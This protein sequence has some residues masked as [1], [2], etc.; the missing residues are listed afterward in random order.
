L[1]HNKGELESARSTQLFNAH[2]IPSTVD[3]LGDDENHS[4]DENIQ[5]E[6]LHRERAFF[7]DYCT[8]DPSILLAQL[9]QESRKG[10]KG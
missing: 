5:Q 4:V 6:A 2:D 9:D 10:R 7:D 3:E 1:R 8:Q